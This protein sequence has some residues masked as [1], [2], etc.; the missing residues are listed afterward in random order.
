M[1]AD[2]EI[3]CQSSNCD[4]LTLRWDGR[5]NRYRLEY[6]RVDEVSTHSRVEHAKI[7]SI[8]ART[9][10]CVVAWDEFVLVVWMAPSTK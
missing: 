3:E 2:P 7:F 1:T 4:S 9:L 5:A 6:R 8:S 10:V